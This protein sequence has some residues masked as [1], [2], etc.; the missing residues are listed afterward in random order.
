MRIFIFAFIALSAVAFAIAPAGPAYSQSC[1]TAD[2]PYFCKAGYR[3]CPKGYTHYC[4]DYTGSLDEERARS[5][6]VAPNAFC[7]NSSSSQF[8]EL[9]T[10]C[11]VFGHC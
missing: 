7:V 9:K 6:R 2:A 1:P 4:K 11:R 3:C 10:H 5:R 8:E